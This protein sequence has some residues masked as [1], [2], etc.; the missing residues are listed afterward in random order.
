MTEW[1]ERTNKKNELKAGI[2]V[3]ESQIKY[4]QGK[5]DTLEAFRRPLE[6]E[7]RLMR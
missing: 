3:L 4:H 5:I 6:R 7:L 2:R 1:D